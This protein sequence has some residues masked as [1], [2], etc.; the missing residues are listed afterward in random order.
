M[1][2]CVYLHACA[3]CPLR[4]E[5]AI[6]YPETGMTD[7]CETPFGYNEPNLGSLEEQSGILI[8]VHLSRF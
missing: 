6:V 3:C 8:A 5:H 4:T 2:M 1:G 7:G